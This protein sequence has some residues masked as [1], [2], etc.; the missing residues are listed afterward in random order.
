MSTEVKRKTVKRKSS[1]ERKPVR[2]KHRKNRLPY[3]LIVLFALVYLPALW[4]WVFHDGIETNVL[5]TGLLEL[6]V[7]SEGVFMRQ[8][9][10]IQSPKEGIVIPKVDSGE[11]VPNKYEIAMLI[12]ESSRQTLKKI[13]DLEESII[14]LVAESNPEMLDENSGFRDK[15]QKEVNK[16]SSLAVNKKLDSLLGIKSALERLLHQRNK[17]VFKD[18]GD[19]LYLKNKKMELEQLRKN[20]NDMATFIHADYS[21]L[22]VWDDSPLDEK[23]DPSNMEQLSLDDLAF[24]ADPGQENYLLPTGMDEAFSVTQDQP[25][26]RL[27]D[28]GKSWYAC[29]VNSKDAKPINAGNSIMLK[30]KGLEGM[31]P[32]TVESVMPLGDKTKV[33]VTFNRMIEKTI[34]LRHVQADLVLKSIDGL[35][36]PIRSLANRNINDNTADLVLV[37]F[38]RA[39]IKRVAVIAEQDTFAVID[40]LTGSMETDP[41][42]IFDIYVVNPQNIVEGQVIE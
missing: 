15:V 33:V 42:S 22:L 27:V 7:P 31:I 36:V 32:C 8:E 14:R 20:L 16:L 12:D 19:R 29:L 18:N 28:N 13:G 17:E 26:A 25:F 21:G 30:V 2:K 3:I 1:P 35:K 5:Y 37:R 41:V 40:T 34:H 39:V 11:R 24:T 9:V 10:S 6:S 4:N 23:Y 38:N